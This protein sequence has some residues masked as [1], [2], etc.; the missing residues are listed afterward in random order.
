M[1]GVGVAVGVG[2]VVAVG[3]GVGVAVGSGVFVGNGVGVF[4]GAGGTVGNGV[5]VL[6]GQGAVLPLSAR[7]LKPDPSAARQVTVYVKLWPQ[8]RPLLTVL[9]THWP[10]VVDQL[11]GQVPLLILKPTAC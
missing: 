8:L 11:K 10:T 6:V 7:P 4:V 2:V 3:R 1:T 9:R 5:G